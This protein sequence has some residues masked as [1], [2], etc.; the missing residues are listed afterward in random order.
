MARNLVVDIQAL[1]FVVWFDQD[2]SGGQAWWDQILASIRESD[3]FIFLLDPHGLKSMACQREFGYAAALGK[4]VLPVL[5]ADGVST[6][7]LPPE[8]SRIQ[9][10]DYRQQDRRSAF[11]LA[12]A[13]AVTPLASALPDILPE[14]PEVPVSYLGG[15]AGRIEKA[16]A[17]SYDEQSALVLDLRRSLRDPNAAGDTRVLLGKL[18]ARRDL[19]AVIA[20]DIDE[21]LGSQ[22]LAKAAHGGASAGAAGFQATPAMSAE[23]PGP[24]EAGLQKTK[25]A[26]LPV[27]PAKDSWLDATTGLMWTTSDNGFGVSQSGAL[28]YCESLR[29]G[30]HADWRLPTIDELAWIY[31]SAVFNHAGAWLKPA[32]WLW[33]SSPGLKSGEA[34][35]FN[36]STGAQYSGG[37]G[38]NAYRALC[39]RSVRK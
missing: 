23:R 21:L 20:V 1:G 18:R 17:L 3:V 25:V 35:V 15:L 27:E 11:A 26:P 38:Y 31:N 19:F 7:L 32:T 28:R 5:V 16:P 10:V 33:S 12:R 29:T 14:P 4:P 37:V 6:N 22:G 30:G 36:F 13:L 24:Q 9:F 34:W 2:L 39:V 8:L